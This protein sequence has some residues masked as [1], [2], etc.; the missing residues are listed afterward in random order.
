MCLFSDRISVTLG[1]TERVQA[2]VRSAARF[3]TVSTRSPFL[4]SPGGVIIS[5]SKRHPVREG[6]QLDV[7]RAWFINVL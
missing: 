7:C 2:V 5:Y 4:S 3:A 6:D 1:Q